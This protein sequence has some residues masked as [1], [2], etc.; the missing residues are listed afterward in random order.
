[1]MKKVKIIKANGEVDF[2]NAEKL[3]YSLERSGASE[4]CQALVVDHVTKELDQGMSTRDIYRHAYKV[5]KKCERH[6]AS[7]YSLRE[8]LLKLGPSGYPFEHYIGELWAAKGYK[9]EV[10]QIVQGQYVQHEVDVIARKSGEVNMM[11]CKYHNQW[12]ARSNLKIALYVD[13]RMKDLAAKC[14]SMKQ[15]ECDNLKGWL[16][17]NTKLTSDAIQYGEGSGLNMM[18][19]AYPRHGNLQEL[20]ESTRLHPITVLTRLQK[21]AYSRLLAKG[22]VLCKQVD[23]RALKSIGLN[24]GDRVKV[25]EEAERLC[26]NV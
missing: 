3:R 19:W 9:V 23:N 16:V 6:G 24:A 22:V 15:Y 1:M 7:R 25:M 4:R 17:T 2:F 12:G 5:L 26:R 20:I 14:S 10:G 11:E 13:A 18:A 21:G 8:A